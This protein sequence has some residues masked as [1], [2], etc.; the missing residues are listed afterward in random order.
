MGFLDRLFGKKDSGNVKME[1]IPTPPC[2]HGSM[3]Q[4][5]DNPDEF[6]QHEKISYYTCD[7]C[8]Q[9]FTPAEA[10]AAMAVAGEG[11]RIDDSLR[12]TTEEMLEGEKQG[13]G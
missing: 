5:W 3:A 6:G 7:S 11:V 1:D 8:G 13:E 2:P 12:K 9:R 4:H 10:E